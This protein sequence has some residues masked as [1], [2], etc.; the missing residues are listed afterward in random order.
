MTPTPPRARRP[1]RRASTTTTPT[2]ATTAATRCSPASRRARGPAARRSRF[3]A[4]GDDLMCG[5][6]TSY[7]I[8]T[9]GDPINAGNFASGAAADRSADAGRRRRRADLCDPASAKRYVAVRAVDDQG[10]VGRSAGVDLGRAPSGPTARARLRPVP[11]APTARPSRALAP[12][13]ARTRSTAPSGKDRLAG[14]SGPDR[15][16]G[17]RR[18][19]PPQRQGR[20]RLR[21]RA[22]AAP[23]RSRAAQATTCSRAAAG[24][25]AS[26]AA[27]ATTRSAPAA[28]GATAST[29]APAD[30]T[31]YL[32]QRTWT[33]RA[34]AR[35]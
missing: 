11:P 25:T 5:T 29:A 18:H 12:M 26:S 32:S 8:V 13:T 22:R 16:R 33:A 10:N 14:T 15:I 19:G 24:A 23:T 17:L 6:A 4:P 30:D 28:A 20:R 35:S 3:T 21:L 31:V 7:E 9:S 2:P 27:P 34:I 1:R